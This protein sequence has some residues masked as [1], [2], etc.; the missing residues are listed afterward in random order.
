MI[1]KTIVNNETGLVYHLQERFRKIWLERKR[2]T[3]FWVFP[4]DEFP[5]ATEHLKR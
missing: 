4:V 3:P 5:G 1:W 2:N